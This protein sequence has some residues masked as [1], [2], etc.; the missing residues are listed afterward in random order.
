MTKAFNDHR[1]CIF[2]RRTTKVVTYM[3]S[4]PFHYL[5]I[6]GYQ[7][8]V[9]NLDTSFIYTYTVVEVCLIKHA[10]QELLVR[11]ELFLCWI[12]HL[13]RKAIL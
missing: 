2:T 3:V 13:S 10:N 6:T 11:I 12:V 8:L 7:I 9:K 1:L 4:L 5:C